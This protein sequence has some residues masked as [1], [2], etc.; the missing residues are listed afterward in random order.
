MDME[1]GTLLRKLRDSLRISSRDLARLVD[2]SHS[3]YMDWEHDKTSPSLK[4][5]VKLAK[6]LETDP[7]DLMAYL[8]QQTSQIVLNEERSNVSEL[9]EMVAYLR[10]HNTGL[11]ESNQQLVNEISKVRELLKH[12]LFKIRN[13]SFR[14]PANK[15]L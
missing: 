14:S 3:T 7:V 10:C 2:V 9:R 13:F 15:P 11:M 1:I 12:S 5:Y 4:S 6:A 8:T